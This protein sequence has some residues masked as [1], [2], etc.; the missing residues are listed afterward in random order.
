L[1][2]LRWYGQYQ[3]GRVIIPAN[4]FEAFD[5]DIPPRMAQDE[6]VELTE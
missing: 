3:S 1:S 4:L 6:M 5:L 2:L